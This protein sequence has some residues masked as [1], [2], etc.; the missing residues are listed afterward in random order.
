MLTFND[1]R[2]KPIW[3]PLS[4][5]ASISRYAKLLHQF[6]RAIA[7]TVD[8]HHPSGYQFSLNSSDLNHLDALQ[9]TL[10]NSNPKDAVEAFHKFIKPILYPRESD[11]ESGGSTSKWDH[12]VECFIALFAL[13][14]DGVFKE[15]NN[16]TGLF[17]IL[18]YHIRCAIFYESLITV[19]DFNN[20]I[21]K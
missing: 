3:K 13:R 19:Q 12:P 21:L 4:D 9:E 5:K 2:N 14:P 20:D 18:H 1:T 8:G 6:A 15:A 17:A 10:T 16:L 7:I 11:P